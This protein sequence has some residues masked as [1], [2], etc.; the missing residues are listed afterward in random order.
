M[1]AIP[2]YILL[3]L[4]TVLWGGNFVIGKAVADHVPPF[5]LAFLRWCVALV[6]FLPIVWTSL[7]RDMKQIMKHY[8]IVIVLGI[9]GVAAFNT[10]VYIGVHY[11][12][13]INASLMNMLTP[14]FIYLLSFIF[15]KERLT[16]FQLIGTAISFIGV[17]L[18]ISH[19]SLQSLRHFAFNKGDLIVIVAV[20][21]WSIYSLLVKQ[22]A[23]VLPGQSTFFASIVVGT[24]ILL[25]FFLFEQ[26]TMTTPIEWDGLA[27]FA[28]GYTG[29]FASIIAFLS[30]NTGVVRYG[31]NRAGIY[32]NF[33]PVFASIF[34]V[35]FLHETLFWSQLLGGAFVIFGVYTT[36]MKR[37]KRTHSPASPNIRS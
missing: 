29:I 17:M 28:V 7:K 34:A 20:V 25:P 16:R 35:I 2:P 30:W 36:S 12:T 10:L 14:V 6:V 15:L 8:K 31:A 5:T 32:L 33:I 26:Q 27:L 24:I 21:L 22:Y 13:S 1:N 19:G 23:K 4:A 18:I 9:T 3:L 37:M 11:T